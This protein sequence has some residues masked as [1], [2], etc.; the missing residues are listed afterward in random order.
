MRVV[1]PLLVIA[2]LA[3]VGCG[4]DD[5]VP[6]CT[7]IGCTSGAGVE[8][9]G[10]PGERLTVK[11]CAAGKCATT[12]STPSDGFGRV[13]VKLPRDSAR[14]TVEV[15]SRGRLLLR[16]SADIPV[17]EFAPNGRRC[18]PICRIATGHLDLRTGRFEPA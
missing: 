13:S 18:G 11:I 8:V 12:R 5:S 17:K 16:R 14:V 4:G 3:P 6:G 1:R 10:R 9:T 7:A 2:L 15:R